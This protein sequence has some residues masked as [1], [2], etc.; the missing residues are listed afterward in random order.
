VIT[1]TATKQGR[2]KVILRNGIQLEA[3]EALNFLVHQI[4]ARR[5]Y[6]PSNLS[7]GRNDIVVD[8]GANYGVFTVFAATLTQSTV[9]AFEPSPT[10]FEFLEQNIRLNELN[11]VVAYKAAI[12]DTV[13]STQLFFDPTNDQGH[14]L[15]DFLIAD[16]LENY[17][18]STADQFAQFVPDARR[19]EKYVTVE[20]STTTLQEIMDR[21]KLERIDFLKLD[22]EGAEGAI[23]HATPREY[24][25][26]V[27][28]IAMEF[29]DFLS[30]FTHED[31]QK[32]LEEVG[33]ITELK[34]EKGAPLGY[35]YAWRE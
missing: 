14:L 2:R 19:V 22:C 35:L 21:H 29:H 7:I 23:V 34:W 11:N 12:S 18:S 6:N 31:I 28:K 33:F 24:L 25:Q 15:V 32:L 20:V 5:V 16:K 1:S 9:Y 3:G 30:Q 13:G 27:R 26:R 17:R 4:F 10:N 8:I